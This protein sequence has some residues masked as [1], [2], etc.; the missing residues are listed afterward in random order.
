MRVI[1]ASFL[2]MLF[3]FPVYAQDAR[4][5]IDKQTVAF[6]QAYTSHDF[7]TLSEF[8]YED[9]VVY[10]Q[11]S[12]IIKG[13]EGIRKL[14]ESKASPTTADTR[15]FGRK[16]VAPGKSSGILGIATAHNES[17]HDSEVRQVLPSIRV[18]R[19]DAQ[20]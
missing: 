4:S 5:E 2:A 11:G 8:Y 16:M 19:I 14:W 3:A 17:L 12:E 18:V 10:P 6:N 1:F 15:Q 13:R 9:A 7:K 20:S